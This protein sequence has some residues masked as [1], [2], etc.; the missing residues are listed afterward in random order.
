MIIVRTG[1]ISYR[2]SYD[3]GRNMQIFL[4]LTS[5]S[6]IKISLISFIYGTRYI[7]NVTMLQ[8][9]N[10]FYPCYLPVGL[11]I[12]YLMQKVSYCLRIQKRKFLI[13]NFEIK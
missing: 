13:L 11:L 2:Y 9:H 3:N 10:A 4:N 1:T 5:Y 8:C 6:D 7:S 12:W